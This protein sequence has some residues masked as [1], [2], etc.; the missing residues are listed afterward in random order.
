MDFIAL[1]TLCINNVLFVYLYRR[2]TCE[3]DG[4]FVINISKHIK[5][6]EN[7]K[8]KLG[9]QSSTIGLSVFEPILKVSEKSLQT[10]YFV[11]SYL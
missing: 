1:R 7:S 6:F 11:C 3:V 8:F 10:Y 5:Y 9:K 4:L 2:A